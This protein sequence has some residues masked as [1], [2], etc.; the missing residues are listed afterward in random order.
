[1]SQALK[2]TAFTHLAI[3]LA[4]TAAGIE[5]FKFEN[6]QALS[7]IVAA[8]ARAGWFEGSNW[9]WATTGGVRNPLDKAIAGLTAVLYLGAG[10]WYSRNGDPSSMGALGLGAGLQAYSAFCA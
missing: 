8:R 4:H 3:A 6:I 2:L 5:T 9:K 7:T 1:M 10:L